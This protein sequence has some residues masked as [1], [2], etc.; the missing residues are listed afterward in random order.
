M[1]SQDVTE[2]QEADLTSADLSAVTDDESESPA[3]SVAAYVREAD[4]RRRRELRFRN[5]HELRQCEPLAV[6]HH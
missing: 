6:A 3:L 5:K 1:Q 2:R 4:V